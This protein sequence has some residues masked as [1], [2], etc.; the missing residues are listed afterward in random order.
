MTSTGATS[1]TCVCMTNME[2]NAD[3]SA[4]VPALCS[5]NG[6][7]AGYCTEPYETCMG[8]VCLPSVCASYGTD[9][10]QTCQMNP[11]NQTMTSTTVQSCPPGVFSCKTAADCSLSNPSAWDCVSGCCTAAKCSPTNPNGPCL[12]GYGCS[13][14]G[15]CV[16]CNCKNNTSLH[17]CTGR[18][19]PP[20]MTCVGGTCQACKCGDAACENTGSC[21]SRYQICMNG[22]CVCNYGFECGP[23]LCEANPGPGAPCPKGSNCVNGFCVR[24]ECPGSTCAPDDAVAKFCPE[25][26]TTCP[27][28]YS[29]L[30]TDGTT[31]EGPF[32][33]V[34]M[35]ST[36]NGQTVLANILGDPL[37]SC[38][39][40]METSHTGQLSTCYL[41]NLQVGLNARQAG[42]PS[43]QQGTPLVKT[44][45]SS[46]PLAFPTGPAVA[47]DSK[48]YVPAPFTDTE[49]QTSL[50]ILFADDNN[51]EYMSP[52]RCAPGG[53]QKNDGTS[54]CSTYGG[55]PC[56]PGTIPVPISGTSPETAW[57]QVPPHLREAHPDMPPYMSIWS[58]S[59][60]QQC[61]DGFV[62]GIYQNAAGDEAFGC[63][64]SSKPL[65]DDDGAASSQILCHFHPDSGSCGCQG[66]FDNP[67][68]LTHN[69][70]SGSC[71][72]HHGN[73][74]RIY[75]SDNWGEATS[76]NVV[77]QSYVYW[78]TPKTSGTPVP[79]PTK[80]D[81]ADGCSDYVRYWSTH[82]SVHGNHAPWS[83]QKS[84]IPTGEH[85]CTA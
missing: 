53:I 17:G 67:D 20:N 38:P 54:I 26:S 46:T 11:T 27:C 82:E 72:H 5:P 69:Y 33:C 48:G 1:G 31:I 42:H 36:W 65:S 2:Y 44:L 57:Y 58:C 19:C 24:Q 14:E 30:G 45:G 78:A 80:C 47:A 59:R 6:A 51:V 73:C 71:S 28:G 68:F 22:Q 79:Y 39:G 75:L 61:A 41:N 83:A 32:N 13:S 40:Y 10:C 29:C 49:N 50:Q 34:P 85:T 37:P 18:G 12:Y 4:C 74:D 70:Y 9:F 55:W 66:C 62:P 60:R 25:L 64:R 7:P 23:N 84:N 8:G 76:A 3:R 77:P 15:K 16:Q 63:I 52:A 81:K 21:P 56:E 35:H 43:Y